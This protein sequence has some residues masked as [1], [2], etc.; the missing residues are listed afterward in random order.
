M[1]SDP[2]DIAAYAAK[3]VSSDRRE[4]YGHPL[5]NFDRAGKIWEA[6]LGIEITAEQVALCM[7]GM[8]IARE[9]HKTKPDTVI[10][11]IGYF[12]TLAAIAEERVVRERNKT[13]KNNLSNLLITKVS[14]ALRG[15]R[16][17]NY[18]YL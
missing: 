11:G 6:I 10:D 15:S 3:L 5:D 18:R 1:L 14:L 4:E 17:P 2:S 13:E 16:S 12:L 8:K 7:V 9:A